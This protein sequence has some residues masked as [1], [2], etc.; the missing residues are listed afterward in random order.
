VSETF[1]EEHLKRARAIAIFKLIDIFAREDFV[2]EDSARRYLSFP[3]FF[4]S[5]RQ[6]GHA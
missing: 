4:H 1:E 2:E 3:V 6:N 5:R